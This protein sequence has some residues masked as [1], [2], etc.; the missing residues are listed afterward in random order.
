MPAGAH[1]ARG[2]T[3]TI[4][5]RRNIFLSAVA[6]LVVAA[7]AVWA[8]FALGGSPKNPRSA[9]AAA[10]SSR[11]SGAPSS[12]AP[13]SSSTPSTSASASPSVSCVAASGQHNLGLTLPQAAS[14]TKVMDV[15]AALRGSAVDN[16]IYMGDAATA[17]QL[18]SWVKGAA[19]NG[20]L[21]SIELDSTLNTL[22]PD[23]GKALIR[24]IDN[25]DGLFGYATSM[26]L[27][28]AGTTDTVKAVNDRVALIKSV[29]KRPVAVL[30]DFFGTASLPNDINQAR[31]YNGDAHV[32][33]FAP[34]KESS[35]GTPADYQMVGQQAVGTDGLGATAALQAFDWATEPATAKNLGFTQTGRP[36]PDDVGSF[37]A[38]LHKAGVHT[39]VIF[40]EGDAA[41]DTT[42]LRA[43]AQKAAASLAG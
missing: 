22:T 28:A 29:S 2:T 8:F 32:P 40:T 30:V 27:C 13:A 18:K 21:A 41:S 36:S 31:A 20:F 9:D 24:A 6:L 3:R 14:D 10:S 5:S 17:D 39:G 12:S 7:L 35:Q 26:N 34:W 33:V 43:V 38:S 25:S 42:Y 16:V 11:H 23:Q 19:C 15:M 37:G 1:P 4:W